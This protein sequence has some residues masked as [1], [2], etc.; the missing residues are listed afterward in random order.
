MLTDSCLWFYKCEECHTLLKPFCMVIAA[1]FA[2]MAPY[3][4]HRFSFQKRKTGTV[5]A[6]SRLTS[7]ESLS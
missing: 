7:T 4:A 1:Y 5:V 6:E 3:Y 2:R